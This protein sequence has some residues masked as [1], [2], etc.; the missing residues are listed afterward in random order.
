ML[1][2]I[3]CIVLPLPLHRG[4]NMADSRHALVDHFPRARQASDT[5]CAQNMPRKSRS[6]AGACDSPAVAY[7]PFTILSALFE[8]RFGG[9]LARVDC[10]CEL[11]YHKPCTRCACLRIAVAVPLTVY[12]SCKLDK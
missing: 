11:W 12:L 9:R 1:R 8:L 10:Q 5:L 7:T 3:G 6:Q 4:P 2:C